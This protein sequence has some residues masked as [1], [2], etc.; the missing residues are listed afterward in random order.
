M[1]A[2]PLFLSVEQV[3]A[4]HARMLK[5]FGGRSGIRDSG[6][7]ASAVAMPAARFGGEFLHDGIAAMAAAYLFH[8]CKNHA[9]I[10]GNKRVALA[11]AAAFLACNGYRLIPAPDE[12]EALT[13]GVA[14][15]SIGKPELTRKLRKFIKRRKRSP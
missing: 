2:E 14:D 10:D 11:S 15:S 6:L 3:R 9:F 5:E 12:L 1:T 8:L 4:I 7:L 13:L